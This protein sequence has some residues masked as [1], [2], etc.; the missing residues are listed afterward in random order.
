MEMMWPAISYIDHLPNQSVRCTI[1]NGN[2]WAKPHY[3]HE[4][5]VL[6]LNCYSPNTWSKLYPK[7]VGVDPKEKHPVKVMFIPATNSYIST[8]CFTCRYLTSHTVLSNESLQCERC[9][10]MRP[11]PQ[12][13]RKG[14]KKD[15]T[16]TL[17]KAG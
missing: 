1:C 2:K 15:V 4:I 7:T 12:H 3:F 13:L 14:D 17:A 6:C 10:T 16:T 9:K 8:N 11:M 5:V